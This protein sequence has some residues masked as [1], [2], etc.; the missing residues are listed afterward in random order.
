M[1]MQNLTIKKKA[2]NFLMA[3]KLEYA[4][5]SP[6]KT[7]NLRLN[8]LRMIPNLTQMLTQMNL[9]KNFL[10]ITK[11]KFYLIKIMI[12]KIWNKMQENLIWKV[13]IRNIAPTMQFAT[14]WRIIC[15]FKIPQNSFIY[16]L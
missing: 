12:G 1:N 10:K 4:K 6:I 9:M 16:V 3:L 15:T 5:E 14:N 2:K 11:Q 7:G 13:F 8:I